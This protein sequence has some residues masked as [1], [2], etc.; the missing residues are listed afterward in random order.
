MKLNSSTGS[1]E[2]S[3]TG[4]AAQAANYRE[5]SNLSCRISTMWR[6]QADTQAA[7]MRTWEVQ[8]LVNVLKS[9]SSKAANR[10]SMLFAQ[11]G[12][13]VDGMA[14]PN[15]QYRL[16]I[17]FGQSI[18]PTWHQYPDFPLEMDMLLSKSQLEKA[19]QELSTQLDTYPE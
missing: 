9:L 12:L 1:F 13:A 17:Q 6:Q 15:D 18:T 11:P 16:N 5:R 14:L 7:S 19:I 2:L 4:Y 8:R 3:I 10:V